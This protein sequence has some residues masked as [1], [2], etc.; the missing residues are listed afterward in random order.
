MWFLDV[1]VGWQLQHLDYNFCEWT[2]YFLLW[3]VFQ[4]P[5]LASAYNFFTTWKCLWS[6]SHSVGRKLNSSGL[7]F[8][9]PLEIKPKASWIIHKS[10]L[11]PKYLK[12]FKKHFLASIAD[13]QWNYF[14]SMLWVL[15]TINVIAPWWLSLKIAFSSSSSFILK[16]W[17][18]VKVE[19]SLNNLCILRPLYKT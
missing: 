12:M 9:L 10:N 11:Q 16:D 4:S 19:V 3:L 2:V 17:L 1:L 5:V 6:F 15:S 18:I 8:L 13:Y 14:Q 7:L